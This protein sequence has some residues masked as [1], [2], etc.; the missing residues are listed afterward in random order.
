MTATIDDERA[1]DRLM[2]LLLIDGPA[3]EEGA[4][5]DFLVE[6]LVRIGVPRDA[7]REDDAPTRIDLPC[8]SGNLIAVIEGTAP[9]PR[10]LLSA[11]MDTVPLA[12]GA[13]PVRRNGRIVAEGQTALGGDDRA[14]VAAVLTAVD[15]LFRQGA[16]HPPLT[17]LFTV[18]EES[19][20][21]GARALRPEDL[22]GAAL[23]FN[24]D[25]S[26]PAAI[27]VGAIGKAQIT[28]E[29][30]GIAAHAGTHPERGVSAVTLF[31][32]ATAELEEA[33]WLGVIDRPEGRGRSN[34]GSVHGGESTNVVTDR[35]L[36]Q[37]EV[38]SH[39]PE[40]LERIVG[41][42]RN[43]FENAAA[44]RQNANGRRGAVDTTVVESYRPFR[45]DDDAPVVTAA[46]AA[47]RNAGLTPRLHV[48]DGG[49]D[50]SWLV[51]YGVPTVTLGTGVHQAHTIDEY[52]VVD[53]L[54]TACRV[55]V[56][57]A[58]S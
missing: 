57:L 11:H 51:R 43:A 1:L 34:I 33:G 2:R 45:L 28:I 19:G 27:T 55:A 39:D 50:A 3:G 12:R 17:I 40:F 7:I 22:A 48:A 24:F 23:G 30:R 15:E 54:L 8:Q 53:E 58:R 9:G 5:R 13:R 31:A 37:A 52:V 44:K 35:L 36:A 47:V 10:R 29:V 4:V 6:E 32:G 20:V 49:V 25:G 38:R 42:Y 14:G 46:A 16:P 26:D 56:E 18:H 41:A 21:R